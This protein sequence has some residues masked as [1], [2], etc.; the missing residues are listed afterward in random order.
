MFPVAVRTSFGLDQVC[1][2]GPRKAGVAGAAAHE[3]SAL[4][5]PA[6]STRPARVLTIRVQHRACQPS[7]TC[8]CRAGWGAV[9]QTGC[10]HCQSAAKSASHRERSGAR[11]AR[12]DEG[13]MSGH[14]RTEEQRCPDRDAWSLEC[15]AAS[16]TDCHGVVVEVAAGRRGR[17]GRVRTCSRQVAARQVA[18][19]SRRIRRKS[20][21]R[22]GQ[23]AQGSAGTG[24][25]GTVLDQAF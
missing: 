25:E 14:L 22:T 16:A 4:V 20:E 2:A 11:P 8:R 3:L 15:S 21:K 9:V 24:K 18:A 23:A 10:G 6:V 1:C 5:T 17:S 19:L 7:V 12:R 13:S